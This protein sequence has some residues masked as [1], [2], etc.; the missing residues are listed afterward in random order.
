MLL[1]L[2][3]C[4]TKRITG[5]WQGYDYDEVHPE[6]LHSVYTIGHELT[7]AGNTISHLSK[8]VVS[9]YKPFITKII[10]ELVNKA[11]AEAGGNPPDAIAPDAI[12]PDAIAPDATPPVDPAPAALPIAP[13][14]EALGQVDLGG[15]ITAIV[16]TFAT[17][18]AGAQEES[19]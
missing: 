4:S 8:T 17:P 6:P 12:A 2:V 11:A 3:V 18:P 9:V 16:S 5:Y 13:L 14:T 15:D 1:T 19:V 7:K 10:T